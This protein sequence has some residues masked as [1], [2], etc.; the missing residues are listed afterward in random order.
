M[1]LGWV[2]L[3]PPGLSAP[4][5]WC[6]PV[7]VLEVT[8]VSKAALCASFNSL[9]VTLLDPRTVWEILVIVA[10]LVSLPCHLRTLR[11]SML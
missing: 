4:S 9:L 5:T 7:M 10:L 6:L 11:N 8:L 3:L 1:V 2:T